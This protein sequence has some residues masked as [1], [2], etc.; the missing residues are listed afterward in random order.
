MRCL[1]QEVVSSPSILSFW[2]PWLDHT[3]SLVYQLA[4]S[5]LRPGPVGITSIKLSPCPT[6]APSLEGKGNKQA[7]AGQLA[8]AGLK[9]YGMW[10]SPIF[11]SEELYTLAQGGFPFSVLA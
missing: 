3:H 6:G 5:C 4:S 10:V 7:V 1:L 8:S 2:S 9:H 11:W